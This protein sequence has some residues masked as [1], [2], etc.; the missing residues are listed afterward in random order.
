M[1]SSM[2]NSSL[3]PAPRASQAA[4]TALHIKIPSRETEEKNREA[5]T[6]PLVTPSPQPALEHWIELKR[7]IPSNPDEEPEILL[8]TTE[9]G[10]VK[11]RH[12]GF[13]GGD[14]LAAKAVYELA[15]FR[16][17]NFIEQEF[18]LE[19]NATQ[20]ATDTSIDDES[21]IASVQNLLDLLGQMEKFIHTPETPEN[22][23]ALAK[24][25][26]E[27]EAQL[28][29][30]FLASPSSHGDIIGSAILNTSG[31]QEEFNLR[32]VAESSFDADGGDSLGEKIRDEALR[33]LSCLNSYQALHTR[34]TGHA[35]RS[36]AETAIKKAIST[37]QFHNFAL[38]TQ[39]KFQRDLLPINNNNKP[40]TISILPYLSETQNKRLIKSLEHIQRH[41]N[42]LNQGEPK[43]QLPPLSQF[44]SFL[45]IPA[46]WWRRRSGV[47]HLSNQ[48]SGFKHIALAVTQMAAIFA[49]NILG[50]FTGI[51]QKNFTFFRQKASRIQFSHE[52]THP[53]ARLEWEIRTQIKPTPTLFNKL[54][55]MISD[56]LIQV[57]SSV[58]YGIKALSF[59]VVNLF[60]DNYFAQKIRGILTPSESEETKLLNIL[61]GLESETLERTNGSASIQPLTSQGLIDDQITRL[62][63]PSDHYRTNDLLGLSGQ[64][65]EGGAL[66]L[67]HFMT[68]YPAFSFMIAIAFGLAA[69][70]TVIQSTLNFVIKQID[71]PKIAEKIAS[72][73]PSGAPHDYVKALLNNYV[74]SRLRVAD[75]AALANFDVNQFTDNLST[76]Q[77]PK[78]HATI[79][80][81]QQKTQSATATSND[82]DLHKVPRKKSSR[83]LTTPI[84]S[85]FPTT[86]KRAF[87]P[88]PESSPSPSPTTPN[89]AS[90]LPEKF[91]LTD[92][93]QK[94]LSDDSS[95]LLN[96]L[97]TNDLIAF[98]LLKNFDRLS[99]L[100]PIKKSDLCRYVLKK[101]SNQKSLADL[102]IQ[103]TLTI[104]PIRFKNMIL[105]ESP[106]SRSL[107]HAIQYAFN[108]INMIFSIPRFLLDLIRRHQSSLLKR[109]LSTTK[110][111]LIDSGARIAS[112]MGSAAFGIS[113]MIIAGLKVPLGALDQCWTLLTFLT[114]K[115]RISSRILSPEKQSKK[116]EKI[117]KSIVRR[118]SFS[119]AFDNFL[120]KTS[121]KMNILFKL[122]NAQKITQGQKIFKRLILKTRT[123]T[124]PQASSETLS[125][126][127]DPVESFPTHP[128]PPNRTNFSREGFEV[129]PSP[130][131][132]SP[133]GQN[134]TH[135]GAHAFF[136]GAI[137]QTLP[138]LVPSNI[139][140]Q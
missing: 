13:L 57:G 98:E 126:L 101:Y 107:T 118:A 125:V 73:F 68:E 32:A 108:I 96:H 112:A 29:K 70:P 130:E 9:A 78:F 2:S 113:H 46:L 110:M 26:N 84:S 76:I 63:R 109:Q 85:A 69:S 59:E 65:L 71:T 20:S 74:F 97:L 103:Q 89:P 19:G 15:E 139:S 124:F 39:A 51:F 4:P 128:S 111:L 34:E 82:E 102:I 44:Q 45:H 38:T 100:S 90:A 12:M 62:N 31:H 120:N 28:R 94:A 18:N 132:D 11:F 8:H 25:W 54:T 1:M 72:L 115:F 42:Y 50:L 133:S 41:A 92:R 86:P 24:T 47:K 81:I 3:E 36:F 6:S 64:A 91:T 119:T 114:Q 60:T 99:S 10:L 40:V 136:G 106:I 5:E 135:H 129:S 104:Q 43:S 30:H 33:V 48:S 83:L 140:Q 122:R 121:S 49:D 22:R 138:G 123:P 58:I 17:R 14:T 131:L 21:M 66:G 80:S 52:P 87:L 137:H 55:T 75:A 37:V 117:I 134:T 35:L 27:Y 79:D 77:P 116:D 88:I 56:V 93:S 95:H 127:L 53:A 67:S 7:Q 16:R 23:E 105:P 61:K